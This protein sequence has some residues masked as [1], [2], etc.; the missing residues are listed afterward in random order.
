MQKGYDI[1]LYIHA[2]CREQRIDTT[3]LHAYIYIDIH[4][5]ILSKFGYQK[6]NINMVKKLNIN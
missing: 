2:N 1:Y 5:E 6:L 3:F 4:I